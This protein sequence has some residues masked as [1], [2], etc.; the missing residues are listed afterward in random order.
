MFL[1]AARALLRKKKQFECEKSNLTTDVHSIVSG[2]VVLL[3]AGVVSLIN[4]VVLLIGGVGLLI[5]GV[6]VLMVRWCC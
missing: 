3:I 1:C 6:V 5:G 2:D 4:G